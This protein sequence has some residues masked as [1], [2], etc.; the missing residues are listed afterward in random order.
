[1]LN[2][3]GFVVLAN[4]AARTMVGDAAGLQAGSPLPVWL[5]VLVPPSLR[6]G[7]S[8]VVCDLVLPVAQGQS[9][10]E[11]FDL[12]GHVVETEG[13][14]LLTLTF[15]NQSDRRRAE[16]N[17]REKIRIE[18]E[19]RA[20][21]LMM[22]Y[23]MHEIGNPLNGVLGMTHMLMSARSDPLS[24]RQRQGLSIVAES[25]EVLRRLL[26]DALDLARHGA[27]KFEVDL[28][29]V[30]L[31]GLID[32]AVA[33]IRSSRALAH[34]VEV[35]DPVCDPSVHVQADPVRLQQCLDN[36]LS[37]ACK[38]SARQGGQVR[39]VVHGRQDA[40][41]IHVIDNG[42]GLEPAQIEQMFKPFERLGPQLAPGHGLGLAV[43][44]MLALAMGGELTVSSRPGFGSD[45]TLSLPTADSSF[46]WS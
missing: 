10:P 9:E 8:P 31:G 42:R 32:T 19:A 20:K 33:L 27:G 28:K 46:A 34:Q 15:H 37:N 22:S 36:L 4:R 29:P 14:S 13:G 25:A 11:V 6:D 23:L 44:R 43:T 17:E 16:A 18:S 39:V 26:S 3:D 7:S 21:Q 40:T 30:R 12:S 41:E 45:F 1:M 24:D 2:A 5:Q 38:Y 35:V